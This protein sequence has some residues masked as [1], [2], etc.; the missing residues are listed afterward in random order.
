MDGENKVGHSQGERSRFTASTGVRTVTVSNRTMSKKGI[1]HYFKG[2][3]TSHYPTVE[4]EHP[5]TSSPIKPLKKNRCIISGKGVR[6]HSTRSTV[7]LQNRRYHADKPKSQM[8]LIIGSGGH[9][10][11]NNYTIPR[12]ADTEST[13]DR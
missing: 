11:T 10:G 5:V 1:I 8:G 4:D 2:K 9:R 13:K 6:P 7:M 3:K 12:K